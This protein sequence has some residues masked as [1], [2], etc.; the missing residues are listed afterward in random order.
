MR[1]YRVSGNC[2]LGG[3]YSLSK[4]FEVGRMMRVFWNCK[5]IR[6]FGSRLVL[7]FGVK[8]EFYL[9]GVCVGFLGFYFLFYRWVDNGCFVY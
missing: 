6:N 7:S 2:V 9:L 1:I 5:R 4:G 8:F 3:G